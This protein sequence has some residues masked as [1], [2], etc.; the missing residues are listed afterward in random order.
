MKGGPRAAL[1]AE[2]AAENLSLNLSSPPLLSGGGGGGGVFGITFSK[3]AVYVAKPIWLFRKIVI[4]S[5]TDGYLGF[6]K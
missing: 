5:R 3:F 1:A 2:S 4:F 6:S